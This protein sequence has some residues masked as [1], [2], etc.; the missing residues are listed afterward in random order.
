[1]SAGGFFFSVCCEAEQEREITSALQFSSSAPIIELVKT[2]MKG[3]LREKGVFIDGGE[4]GKG[5]GDA[6][7]AINTFSEMFPKVDPAFQNQIKK[8]N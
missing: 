7:G 6:R 8:K 5:R 2:Q 4:I 3:E 1:M